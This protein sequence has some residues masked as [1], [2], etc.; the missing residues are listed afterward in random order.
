MQ[1]LDSE[2]VDTLFLQF[3]LLDSYLPIEEITNECYIGIFRIFID[4]P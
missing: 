1:W 3:L 2:M 4:E